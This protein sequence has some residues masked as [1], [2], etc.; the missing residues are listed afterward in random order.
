MLYFLFSFLLVSFFNIS[1]SA[2]SAGLAPY[3]RSEGPLVD[4][5]Y[6]VALHRNHTL[7]AHFD[8]IGLNLSETASS[9]IPLKTIKSYIAVLDN[10][11]VHGLI[12]HDP[13]VRYVEHDAWH[14]IPEPEIHG[15]SYNYTAP[16]AELSRRWTETTF[17]DAPWWVA[18]L[19][20]AN[21]LTSN[22]DTSPTVTTQSYPLRIISVCPTIANKIFRLG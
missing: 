22:S 14:Q 10:H 8:F 4:D 12:R 16:Q 19:T 1:G 18:M 15:P 5:S 13:G 21:K 6:I 7:E 2:A 17:N 11:T 3:I 9:F 20:V